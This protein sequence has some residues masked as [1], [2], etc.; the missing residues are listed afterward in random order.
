MRR[1]S[2]VL[3]SVALLTAACGGN[4][5]DTTVAK[6]RT[7][8]V[9]GSKVS[10]PAH[11]QRIVL[12][13]QPTLAAVTGLGFR[14]VGT[15]GEKGDNL[16]PYLPTGYSTRGLTLVSNT[17]A[18]DDINL[19]KVSALGPDL[20]IGVATGNKK[21]TAIAGD[22]RKIAP[23]VILNWAGSSS[24]RQH[25]TDVATVLGAQKKAGHV[26]ADYQNKINQAK[27][28]LHDT[29]R[30]SISIVRI[31]SPSE[32]RFEAPVSFPGIVAADLGFVRP[33]SQRVPDKGKDFRSESPER[34]NDADGDLLFVLPD[35]DNSG[36][37]GVV[38]HSPLWK[39]LTAVRNKKAFAVDYD[40]WGAT[41]YFGATRIVEDIVKA[42]T[43]KLDPLD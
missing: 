1:I 22:L 37:A 32:L 13:W 40:Y 11:P 30:T 4:H 33:K 17:T 9:D 19:E 43:G 38:Q 27:R 31:Q 34:L 35:L 26:V 25:F 5:D 41:D 16:A 24:W 6:T 21:Q 10:I 3:L 20:I 2:A 36:S 39:T 14:P 29:A 8:S 12:L 18:P 28:Q 42:A 15:A 23:T 7:I